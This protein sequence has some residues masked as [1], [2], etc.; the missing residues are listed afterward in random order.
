MNNNF[1]KMLASFF[2]LGY[3]P[4]SPGTFGTLGGVL[5]W[6]LMWNFPV[7]EYL[8]VVIFIV[9]IS[10]L[11][12]H[13]AWHI[14]GKT[15]NQHIVIDEVAGFLVSMIGSSYT[16]YWGVFG[17]ILFR[18]F[19]IFKPFPVRQAEDLYGGIGIVADD[20]VAGILAMMVMIATRFL[21]F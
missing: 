15:D 12:S 7:W 9:I 19:D 13:K 11:I 4:K 20:V 8:I 21:F 18:I 3:L 10:T 14:Y 5:I 17:F 1:I 16:W 6:I 2:G